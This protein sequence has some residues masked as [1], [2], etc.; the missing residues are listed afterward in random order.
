MKF[1]K[2]HT[3]IDSHDYVKDLCLTET[4]SK[5]F[6]RYTNSLEKGYYKRKGCL[7]KIKYAGEGQLVTHITTLTLVPYVLNPI[8]IRPSSLVEELHLSLGN[9]L[10]DQIEITT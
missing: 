10:G 2:Q 7:S 1:T 9:V 8:S 4:E 3:N 6:K 5:I